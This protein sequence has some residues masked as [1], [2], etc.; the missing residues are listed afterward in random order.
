MSSRPLAPV[1]SPIAHLAG[2]R[3]PVSRRTYIG[4]GVGLMALKFSVDAI[5]IKLLAGVWI[6]PAVYLA[7]LATLRLEVLAAGPAWL[8][9]LLVLG[10]LPFAWVGGSMSVRRARDAGLHPALGMLFFV[11]VVQYLAIAAL[12]SLPTR[13]RPTPARLPL[14]GAERGVAA[15]LVGVAGGASLAIPITAAST[16]LLG[17]YGAALFV[18]GPF[19]MAAVA[20]MLFNLR[21]TQGVLSTAMVGLATQAV[22]GG[23]LLLFALEGVICLAMAAPLAAALGIVGALLGRG[24]AQVEARRAVTAPMMVLPVIAVVEPDPGPAVVHMAQTEIVVEA[25]PEVIWDVVVAFPEIPKEDVPAWYFQA[26]VAWPQRARIE[27]TGVGA[28]RYCEFSTGPF[29]EPI[30]VWDPPHH[31][32][33]DVTDSPPPMEEM[34]MWQVVHAPHIFDGTLRSRRGEFRLEPLDD[35]RRTRLVGRTWYTLD[36]APV[37]YW[38]TWSTGLIHRIHRRVLQHIGRV[39]ESGLS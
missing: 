11:P 28:I 27:G 12:A 38:S 29:V 17:D 26:G 31:L 34:S 6:S 30:T 24:L 4:T 36:M 20:G 39:A 25:P 14:Q 8:P 35:G 21:R 10:T 16:L 18:G 32:A 19:M 5:I 9:A 22:A 7:P 13:P 3:V 15:A 1:P 2:F 33:F 23:L 37:A